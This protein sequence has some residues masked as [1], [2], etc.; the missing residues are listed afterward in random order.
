MHLTNYSVNKKSD[1]YVKNT[2]SAEEEKKD[3]MPSKWDLKQLREEYDRM[4]ISFDTVFKDISDVLIK[5]LISV[6]PAISANM[7]QVKNKTGCFELYGFD[8]I[9]D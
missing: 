1:V 8:V 4:G 3:E 7:R 5:T 9:I 2:K 6:E